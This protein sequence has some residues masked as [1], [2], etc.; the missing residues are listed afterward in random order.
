MYCAVKE[1]SKAKACY[2]K[3]YAQTK[4][5]SCIYALAVA[6]KK[7]GKKTYLF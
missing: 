3:A 2:L 7:Q 6:Y 4:D 1:I 5:A